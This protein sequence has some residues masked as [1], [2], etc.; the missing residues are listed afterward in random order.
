MAEPIAPYCKSDDVAALMPQL[1]RAGTDFSTSTTP[2]RV[3]VNKFIGWV[4]SEIDMKFA[5]VGYVVPYQAISGEDWPI[6][7]THMLELMCSFG[8]AGMI[9]GP[10]VKPA[11]AMGKSSGKS[12]NAFTATYKSF[13]ESIPISG[14]GFRMDYHPGSHAEQLCRYPHGP[15]T[16]HLEGYID[17]TRFQTT[18]EYTAVVDAV[19]DAYSIPS[20]V[21]WFDHLRI[22]RNTLLA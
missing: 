11:P 6:A 20:G 10:V 7:Q 17:T 19:R 4:S 2:T 15:T 22:K 3:V 16:D 1:L 9:V 8:V 18:W 14:A 21:P 5:S 13:L 12:D